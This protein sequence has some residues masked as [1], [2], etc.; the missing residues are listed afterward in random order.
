MRGMNPYIRGLASPERSAF[1]EK[2]RNFVLLISL[3]IWGDITTQH[4]YE[5]LEHSI[6]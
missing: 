6:D 3:K 5:S 4:V 1:F 2:A